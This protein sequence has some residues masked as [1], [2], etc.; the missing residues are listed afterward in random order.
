MPGPRFWSF[1]DLR[2][3]PAHIPGVDEKDGGSVRA[4]ARLA[5]HALA[6]PLKP[7]LRRLDV[8]DLKA[9]V[10]LPALRIFLVGWRSST[11]V[12]AIPF[13]PGVLTKQTRTCWLSSTNGSV[14]SLAPMTSR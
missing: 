5:E 4:N 8:G 2:E 1:H 14:M 10:M 6:L 7:R 12:P 11:W 3:Y 9:Q 13:S